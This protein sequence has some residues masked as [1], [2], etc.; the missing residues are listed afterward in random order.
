MIPDSATAPATC[1][2]CGKLPAQCI[3]WSRHL[4]FHRGSEQTWRDLVGDDTA[5]FIREIRP[6]GQAAS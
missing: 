6:T 3:D 5:A 1:W 4:D 2:W